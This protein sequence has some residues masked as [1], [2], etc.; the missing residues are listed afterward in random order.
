MLAGYTKAS[1]QTLHKVDLDMLI[2]YLGNHPCFSSAE[3]KGVKTL[4]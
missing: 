4:K 3:M 2:D 1:S